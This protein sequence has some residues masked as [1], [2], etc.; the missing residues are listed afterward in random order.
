MK[1]DINN[2]ENSGSDVDVVNK[3]ANKIYNKFIAGK[4]FGQSHRI[5]KDLRCLVENDMAFVVDGEDDLYSSS[6]SRYRVCCKFMTKYNKKLLKRKRE[7]TLQFEYGASRRYADD[8]PKIAELVDC[9]LANGTYYVKLDDKNNF[10]VMNIWNS[11]KD[12]PYMIG[13]EMFIIGKKK[14]KYKKKFLK[15]YD[16]YNAIKERKKTERILYSD[17]DATKIAIF[18]SFDDIVIK[19]KE[20]ILKYIDNWIRNIPVYYKKYHCIPK[21]SVLIDGVPGSGK[22]TFYRALAKLLG[23][24]D[25]MCIKPDFFSPHERRYNRRYGVKEYIVAIDDIDCICGARAGDDDEEDD[26]GEKK[27]IYADYK[28][29]MKSMG[30][31]DE[32]IAEGIERKKKM[33]EI[34]AAEA[35]KEKNAILS[36]LL[37]YLDNPDT[38]YYKAEDGL[39]Y[40][41]QVVVATTNHKERLDSAVKRAGRF[42]LQFEMGY[43]DMTLAKELC[44]KYD[45]TI[46]DVLPPEVINVENFVIRPSKLEALCKQ[47]IDK[48]LKKG[49]G[50]DIGVD[51]T[52][53]EGDD[54]TDIKTASDSYTGG[55]S[56]QNLRRYQ[57]NG[58]ND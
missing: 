36:N 26:I 56:Q 34:A 13:Y 52:Y 11:N 27:D 37:A 43:F 31:T 6:L 19:D 46:E 58:D 12:D 25:V 3:I 41:V 45:L 30:K 16:E 35:A 18:K 33:A 10:A 32:E 17:G 24:S 40:P 44:S 55:A 4:D 38:F 57:F 5:E 53:Y 7:S 2:L 42:D 15:L 48:R 21:L 1:F 28:A 14:E 8:D 29:R 39:Y 9:S 22:S 47:N 23:I 54:L 20:S 49:N 51:A 50:V